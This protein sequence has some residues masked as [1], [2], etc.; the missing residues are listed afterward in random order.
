MF[1][2]I[3]HH[4]RPSLHS[5]RLKHQDHSLAKGI[6]VNDSIVDIPIICNVI[7]LDRNAI[8]HGGT[9]K[10]PFS[11]ILIIS[12]A[13]SL[14]LIQ[15][16]IRSVLRHFRHPAPGQSPPEKLPDALYRKYENGK[17]L[18]NRHIEQRARTQPNHSDYFLHW[19]DRRNEPEWSD[20]KHGSGEG[21][22]T[23]SKCHGEA[24]EESEDKVKYVPLVL[25]ITH[26]LRECTK[27]YQ[28]ER[29]FD[30]EQEIEEILN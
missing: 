18:Q 16:P 26:F 23:G 4:P 10:R 24:G 8:I 30:D 12:I 14:L 20:G 6:K 1:S 19:T 7:I 15:L 29:G 9:T 22:D 5:N 27:S 17:K 21:L 11:T 28:F 3:I 13:Q 25:E 2:Y